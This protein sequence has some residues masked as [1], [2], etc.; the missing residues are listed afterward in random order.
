MQWLNLRIRWITEGSLIPDEQSSRARIVAAEMMPEDF[1][2][3]SSVLRLEF[4]APA[5]LKEQFSEF[6][7]W[8][9][10][11]FESIFLMLRQCGAAAV[12]VLRR[13]TTGVY[14]WQQGMA[15][16]VLA[17]LASQG[18]DTEATAQLVSRELKY[19]RYETLQRGL[20]GV[21]KLAA[22]NESV[23]DAL[24][25]LGA[26]WGKDD[27]IEE[28]GILETLSV[29]APNVAAR[30]EAELYNLMR[31]A[32]RG[33]PRPPILEGF[34][35][36][37]AGEVFGEL[38]EASGLTEDYHAIRAALALNRIYPDRPEPRE[39][40]EH[41]RDHHGNKSVREQLAELL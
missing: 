2:L 26:D 27:P 17:D 20:N 13:I 24:L 12:P 6:C 31:Q 32:G 33:V 8:A 30:R 3:I 16:G 18:F 11:R 37:E 40:L 14:D 25:K 39:Q 28:L 7:S 10:A 34:V 19:W 35:V 38:P 1:D 4:S 15:L 36:D 41:W 21:C 9:D 29:F 22:C 23:A 5:H